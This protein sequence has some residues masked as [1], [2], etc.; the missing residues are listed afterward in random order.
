[1][2]IYIYRE[3]PA[4]THILKSWSW[5]T[6]GL[7]GSGFVACDAPSSRMPEIIAGSVVPW[8]A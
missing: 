3:R 8:E 5:V 4:E 6:L 1:M 7:S 2:Y